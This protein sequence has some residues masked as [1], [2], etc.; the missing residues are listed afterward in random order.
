MTLLVIA[1][2]FALIALW[3]RIGL[4][5]RS[6]RDLPEALE[7]GLPAR[8]SWPRLSI[9]IPALN[10]GRTIG[11]AIKTLLAVDYPDLEIVCVNDRST[12]DTGEV[13][14][15]VAATDSRV[16]AIQVTSL[17]QGWIGKVHALDK[18]LQEAT[19]EFIL[20][21]D[22]D[23]HFS[24]DALKRAVQLMEVRRL[25]HLALTPEIKP[26]GFLFDIALVQA[27]WTLFRDIDPARMGRDDCR[28]PMGVGAFNLVRGS[29]IRQI[30]PFKKLRME[31]ID[32]IGLAILCHQAGGRG[33]LMNSGPAVSLEYYASFRDMVRGMEKNAFAVVQYSV[34]RALGGAVAVGLMLILAFGVPLWRGDWTIGLAAGVYVFLVIWQFLCLRHLGTRLIHVLGMPVGLVLALWIGINSMLKTIGRGGIEWRGTTYPLDELRRLQVT[35]FPVARRKPGKMRSWDEQRPT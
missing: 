26:A 19:G 14:A 9:L 2:Q 29:L 11:P 21:T 35:R 6:L 32:D 27:L 23:I 22:A 7:L 20:C 31:V 28:A 18:A 10:E 13:I 25:D 34:I 33:A 4:H 12:D 16:K 1:A 5:T 15:K 8:Q 17:P 3:I 30:Q 24:K